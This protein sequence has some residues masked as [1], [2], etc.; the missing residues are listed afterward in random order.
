MSTDNPLNLPTSVQEVQQR[1]QTDVQNALPESNP[2]LP[3]SL[4]NALITGL[5]GSNYDLY[6]QIGIAIQVLFPD[7]A[8]GIYLERWGSWVGITR[9]PATAAHGI[10]VC[11]GTITTPIPLGTNFVS[12]TSNIYTS[13]DLATISLVTNNVLTLSRVGGLVTAITASEHGFATGQTVTIIGAGQPE[14][15]GPQVIIVVSPTEFEYTIATTPL[16]PAT[17]TITAAAIMASVPVLSQALGASQNAPS[18]DQ[19]T[20]QTPISGLNNTAFANFF[21]IGGGANVES[22]TA[23]RERVHFRYQNPVSLFNVNA[24]IL[25]AKTVPGVTRVWVFPITPA[26]GYVTVFF[27]RDNDPTIIPGPSQITDV[28]NALLE[29]TPANTPPSFVIVDAPTPVI[30][31]FSFSA[32]N[33]NTPTMQAAISASLAAF[34]TDSTSVGVSVPED[35]Y[36]C[37]IFSTI[38]PNTGQSVQSFSLLV[39]TTDISVAFDELAVLGNITYP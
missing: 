14:Y 2:F 36:R 28:H 8:P 6:L 5:A 16:T 19:L 23:Y 26:P 11:T 7:T 30:V 29:I 17:G 1:I 21:G 18:G 27:V 37:A 34:F 4:L 25:Q 24:I 39:P 33:P 31:D 22:D 10:L 20:V 15:N 13:T 12:T 32:I 3:N 35:A 9:L 38:D